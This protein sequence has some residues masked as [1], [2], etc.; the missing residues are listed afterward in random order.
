MKLN[1]AELQSCRENGYLLLQNVIDEAMLTRLRPQN[2]VS[3]A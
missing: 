3:H 1:R 2:G